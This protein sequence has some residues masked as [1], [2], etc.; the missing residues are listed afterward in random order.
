M[1]S[2]PIFMGDNYDHWCIKMKFFLKASALWEIVE[3][4]YEE[5][6]E[7]VQYTDAKL[8]KFSDDEMKDASL[9]SYHQLCLRYNFSQNNESLIRKRNVETSLVNEKLSKFDG[10]R[11]VDAK[12]YRSLVGSLLYLTTTR[13]DV[14]FATSLLSRFMTEPNNDWGGSVD[15]MKSILGYAFS[16]GSGVF[17]WISKKKILTDLRHKQ[18]EATKVLVDNKSAIDI[19]ENIVCFSKRKHMKIKYY[20]LHEAQQHKEVKLVHCPSEY[21]LADILTKALPKGRFEFLR[22]KLGMMEKSLKEE[23]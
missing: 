8:K 9:I 10:R 17:S 3:I 19:S 11:K 7:D 23:Y 21:Q 4:G 14:V 20:A 12:E 15:D 2:P 22:L 6:K 13:P 5:K 1:P 16:L 18:E